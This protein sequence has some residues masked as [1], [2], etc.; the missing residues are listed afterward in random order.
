MSPWAS[1]RSS[2][3]PNFE[4]KDEKREEVD[5]K[6]GPTLLIQRE[7]ISQ[8]VSN[9]SSSSSYTAKEAGAVPGIY[10]S[11]NK[12]ELELII[13]RR[14][15]ITPPLSAPTNRQTLLKQ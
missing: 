12:R 5:A 14:E 9:N 4:V 7:G 2:T 13:N 3:R 6:E 15:G 10:F 11:H 1:A 8:L